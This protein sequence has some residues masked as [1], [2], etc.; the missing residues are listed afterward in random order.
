MSSDASSFA[1]PKE[2]QEVTVQL[3]SGESL[4]GAIFLEFSAE[5]LA[6]HQKVSDFLKN[7]NSFFPLA[8]IGSGATEFIN[9][10][11]IRYVEL[12][13]QADQ[14]GDDLSLSLMHIENIT[15]VFMD[16]STMNGALMAEVPKEKAR[17]SDCL[18]LAGKFLSVR[19]NG[20]ICF[21]NKGALR[22]VVY[23]GKL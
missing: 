21:V 17:L 19:V 20:K 22:K 15:A 8:L 4:R 2:R 10:I 23:A 18:N 16:G 5:G 13:Y 6:T 7:G 14:N 1:V 9:T 12:V 11:N 3:D